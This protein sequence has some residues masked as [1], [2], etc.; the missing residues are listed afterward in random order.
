MNTIFK[1]FNLFHVLVVL[2]L[3]QFFLFFV[4]QV[5]SKFKNS[6][7]KNNIKKEVRNFHYR[8]GNK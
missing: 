5:E 2:N 6:I 1:W 7:W 8:E 3:L 4:E